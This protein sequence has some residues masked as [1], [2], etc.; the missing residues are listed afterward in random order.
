MENAIEVRNLRKTF[1]TTRKDPGLKGSIRGLFSSRAG[2]IDALKGISF[3]VERGE[4]VA[5]IGPNGAGKST[6][7]KAITGILHPDAGEITVL[8][9]NPQRQRRALS[10]RIGTVFGQKSQLWF[11][12]P[13]SDSFQLLGSIYDLTSEQ[14]ER[15]IEYL[16]GVFEIGDILRQPVR[17]LSLGQRIRCEIAASLIHDPE[18]LFLNIMVGFINVHNVTETEPHKVSLYGLDQRSA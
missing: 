12:L 10:Y 1:R 3:S 13:P 5:F 15:R 8:G 18:I 7:I 17:K 16:A 14:T 4:I 9:L 6:A 11:H 2:T